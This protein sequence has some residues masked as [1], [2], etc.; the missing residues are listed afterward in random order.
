VPRSRRSSRQRQEVEGR[1]NSCGPA[2]QARLPFSLPCILR[3][4]RRGSLPPP[5]SSGEVRPNHCSPRRRRRGGCGELCFRSELGREGGLAACG[6]G[7]GPAPPSMKEGLESAGYEGNGR[8]PFLTS[9]C[10]NP[11]QRPFLHL[12][13]TGT[14]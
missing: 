1:C 8:L 10:R 3:Q 9:A 2:V 14:F 5:V 6:A 11:L 12:F 4:R 7:V 13:S